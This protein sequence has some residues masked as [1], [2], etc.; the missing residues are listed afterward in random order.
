MQSI[1]QVTRTRSSV[2]NRDKMVASATDFLKQHAKTALAAHIAECDEGFNFDQARVVH[3]ERTTSR[4]RLLESLYIYT[5]NTDAMNYRR[6]TEHLTAATRS[7]LRT[8]NQLPN[9]NNPQH[10]CR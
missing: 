2:H 8:K 3:S 10:R 1:D 9:S 4:R 7:L 5:N 6:D